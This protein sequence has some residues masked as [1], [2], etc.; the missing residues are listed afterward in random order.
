M[1]SLHLSVDVTK[2]LAKRVLHPEREVDIW[3]LARR[4]I[5]LFCTQSPCSLLLLH[6]ILLMSRGMQFPNFKSI[7][8][9]ETFET[10][11]DS[12]VCFIF[13]SI[14]YVVFGRL[15]EWQGLCWRFYHCISTLHSLI[16]RLTCKAFSQVVRVT[17]M[18]NSCGDAM[19]RSWTT[20]HHHTWALNIFILFVGL[21][22]WVRIQCFP[23]VECDQ[24]APMLT[25]T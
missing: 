21:C 22:G 17:P 11:P 24:N 9:C 16:G 13:G 5:P 12:C 4:G 20:T 2:I 7:S 8:F 3:S 19:P 6:T 15:T 10:F 25:G 1:G 18:Q 14:S 23:H